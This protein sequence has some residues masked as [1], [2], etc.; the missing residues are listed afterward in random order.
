MNCHCN[1]I[2]DLL[3]LYHDGICSDESNEIIK[4]H[5]AEC[6][7]CKEYYDRLCKS[8]GIVAVPQSSESEIKK[9]DSFKGI[10]KRLRRKQIFV[11]AAVFAAVVV[12]ALSI[13]GALKST[14]KEIVYNGNITVSMTDGSLIGRL[15]GNE[16]NNL[17]IKRVELS[18][19]EKPSTYIFFGL[20]GTKWAELVTGENTFSEYSLCPADKDADSVDFV[21]YCNGN[22]DEL[23]ELSKEE[24]KKVLDES[25]LLW[26][27]Q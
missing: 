2:R 21:Y 17:E 8:D 26:S 12:L 25:T 7:G 1:L 19:G 15:A 24:F 6:D 22:L 20:S 16:A 14:T 5:L 23:E 9:A 10:K 13:I 27:K 4:A 11:G 18:V 3:P